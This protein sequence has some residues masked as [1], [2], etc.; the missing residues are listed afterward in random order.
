MINT[1]RDIP[2]LNLGPTR[3]ALLVGALGAL[4]CGSDAG[5]S[6]GGTGGTD[7]QTRTAL[8]GK[9]D[10]S[11][12]VGAAVVCGVVYAADGVTPLPVVEVRLRD[13]SAGLSSKGVA[14]PNKCITDAVGAFA[15][16]LPEGTTGTT[17]FTVVAPGFD[18]L[19][20]TVKVVEGEIAEADRLEMAA[21]CGDDTIRETE[22]CDGID[23][24][25]NTCADFGFTGGTLGC[26]SDCS[27]F[28]TSGCS[29]G[30]VCGDNAA[31]P[32]EVCD[33]TDL[34]GEDCASQGFAGGTLGCKADCTGFDTGGCT[35][36]PVCG[37]DAAE[38]PEVCDGTD[39]AGED[40]ASQGFAGGT[41]GC[42]ADCTGFDTGGCTGGGPGDYDIDLRFLSSLS[43][44]V[45]QTFVDAVAR[46]ESVV[47]GDLPDV[48]VNVPSGLC[49]QG[50]PAINETIDDLLIFADVTFIDGPGG[51]LG[52]A[53]TCA[54]RSANKLTVFGL[55]QFD[56]DDLA[57]LDAQGA[58]GD[59]IVHE[60]GHVI[61]FGTVWEVLG[62]LADPSLQGGTDPHFTGPRAI[63]AFDG[64][65]GAGYSG[66]KVPVENTGGPGTADG[67]WRESVLDNELMT[68]WLNPGS[69]PLSELTVESLWDM[70]YS[71][72]LDAADD[73]AITLDVRQQS[74]ATSL[75]LGDDI[76]TL[77]IWVVDEE[78]GVVEVIE[79]R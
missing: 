22:T 41:L 75:S 8:A 65:G 45:Q 31:E 20:F 52:R 78:G 15:C 57:E 26:L 76:L 71:V 51:I 29:G 9:A 48:P 56:E 73:F 47:I 44:S 79:N 23:L 77:P 17:E 28:D 60:M 2:M 68:G 16:I 14:D 62:F 32:P 50:Q 74:A 13:P 38:P 59:V 12:E 11:P 49:F 39:L 1:R 27:S 34:A 58:L 72:D 64:L 54:I 24:A 37:D 21:V 46:W 67:H 70:G 33:G 3:L 36:G 5:V 35:S 30:P 61:G 7:G 42:E 25:G 18:T 63:A 66:A 55:M 4:G 10:C 6:T 53:G 43:P 69:N 40:C 19:S